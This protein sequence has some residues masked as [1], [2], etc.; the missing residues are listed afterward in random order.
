[1]Q[2]I[3]E[4]LAKAKQIPAAPHTLPRLMQILNDPDADGSQ[5]VELVSYDAG[6][7]TSVLRVCNSALFRGAGQVTTVDEAILRIGFQQVYRLVAAACG[8]QLMQQ[9]KPGWGVNT[10]LLWSHSVTA[11]IAA[12]LV[13]RE[14]NVEPNLVFTGGLMHDLG[15][16]IMACALEHIYGNLV[17]QAIAG[18]STLFA[19]EKRLL[20]VH[21]AEVA[22]RLLVRWG[23]PEALIQIVTHHHAPSAAPVADQAAVACVHIGNLIAYFVGRHAGVN[24]LC[25]GACEESLRIL[26]LNPD[27]LPS[28]MNQTWEN[29]SMVEMFVRMNG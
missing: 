2:E 28:F 26:G 22:G 27:R 12:Q 29:A 14:V 1:M 10:G 3:D 5:A 16:I 11:G 19:T 18:E 20:G 17:E 4:F 24:T 9:V 13:A 15:K 8:V 21:H 25:L 6:L 7:T 23:F